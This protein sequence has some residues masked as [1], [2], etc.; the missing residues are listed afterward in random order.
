MKIAKLVPK[1][2]NNV[3]F[4][5]PLFFSIWIYTIFK[6]IGEGVSSPKATEQLRFHLMS[7]YYIIQTFLTKNVNLKDSFYFLQF[8][9]VCVWGGDNDPKHIQKNAPP[10]FLKYTI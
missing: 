10:Y 8:V 7:W 4:S 5:P 9:C 2:E 1:M 3:F 6:K